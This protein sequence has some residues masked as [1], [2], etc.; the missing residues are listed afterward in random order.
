MIRRP[1]KSTPFP[2]T[3]LFQSSDSSC[4]PPTTNGSPT[5][6]KNMPQPRVTQINRESCAKHTIFSPYLRIGACPA[7]N[8]IR[9]EEH[10]SELQSRLHLV[11]RLLLEK[12]KNYT[13]NPGSN[14]YKL[15]QSAIY[16]HLNL[17]EN[18]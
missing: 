5:S 11:C 14:Q 18:C 7:C 9:S 6:T 4:P 3:T 1:P 13:T 10:T 12:K 2:S 17:I 15:N 16:S 8:P